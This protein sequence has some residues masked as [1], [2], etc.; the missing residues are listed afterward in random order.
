MGEG[1]EAAL[2]VKKKLLFDPVCDFRLPRNGP[3]A[4]GVLPL[5]LTAFCRLHGW[6][7]TYRPRAFLSLIGQCHRLAG[8]ILS[9]WRGKKISPFSV[10]TSIREHVVLF[11]HGITR[12]ARRVFPLC[13]LG[14]RWR[15]RGRKRLVRIRIFTSTIGMTH[16][17]RVA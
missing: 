9:G 12:I 7:R 1:A 2:R 11:R 5:R 15:A 16:T 4:I 8:E 6:A 14:V 10:P 17:I 3:I 13:R